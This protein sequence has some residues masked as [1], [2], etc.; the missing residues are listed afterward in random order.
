MIADLGDPHVVRPAGGRTELDRGGRI[1]GVD[2][3]VPE[4]VSPRH[5]HGLADLVER[6]AQGGHASIVGVDEV[7]DLVRGRQPVDGL[8]RVESRRGESRLRQHDRA[9]GDHRVEDVEQDHEPAATRVDDPGP[10]QDVELRG[11][12]GQCVA[13][14]L[15]GRLHNDD[16]RVGR[17][18]AGRLGSLPRDRQHGSLDRLGHRGV[19][20]N[21]RPLEACRQRQTVSRPRLRREHLR[22]PAQQLAQDHPRAAP[23]AEQATAE[24][25]W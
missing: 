9:L 13:R 25:S 23:G 1:V 7:H 24:R 17:R 12:P 6:G 5:D 4:P 11:R 20:E 15:R 19:G 8:A 18:G 16:E 10:T 2:V 21:H 14:R 3:H 22:D